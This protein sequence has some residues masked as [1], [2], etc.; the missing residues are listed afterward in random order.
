MILGEHAPVN[1]CSPSDRP[2]RMCCQVVDPNLVTRAFITYGALKFQ[3]VLDSCSCQALHIA[4]EI[5]VPLK[6]YTTIFTV[7]NTQPQHLGTLQ[8]R[9]SG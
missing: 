8:T 9:L 5:F 1:S 2:E 6:T 7:R 4:L 3:A